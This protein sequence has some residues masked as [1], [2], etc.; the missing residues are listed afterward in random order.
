MIAW[1]WGW[2]DDWVESII[3]QLPREVQFMSVSEWGMP[4]SRGG[5]PTTVGEYSISTIGPGDRARHYWEVAHARGMRTL[6]KMQCGNTWELS[7]VPYIP[8]VANVARHAAEP[9]RAGREWAHAGLDVGGVSVAQPRSGG[10]DWIGGGGQR[11]WQT[12]RARWC[13]WRS[14]ISGRNWR[15]M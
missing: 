11:R 13:G 7:S 1:D 5:V 14:G 12:W 15:H 10:G 4:I 2:H 6:A 8:A 9:S 3:A